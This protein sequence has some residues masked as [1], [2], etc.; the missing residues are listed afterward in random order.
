[1]KLYHYH[2]D[3]YRED[4]ANMKLEFKKQTED[5]EISSEQYSQ[6]Q[7][8]HD[9]KMRYLKTEFKQKLEKKKDKI[10]EVSKKNRECCICLGKLCCDDAKP[11]KPLLCAHDAFHEHCIKR[12]VESQKTCPK[13]RAACTITEFRIHEGKFKNIVLSDTSE[14]YCSYIIKPVD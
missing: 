6:L 11:A 8:E 7:R 10:I 4:W 5:I 13:C 1:M 2:Y 14:S 12:W 9:E 3:K